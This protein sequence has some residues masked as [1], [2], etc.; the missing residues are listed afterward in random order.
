LA[1]G[2]KR[3]VGDKRTPEGAF[4]ICQKLR[5]SRKGGP[6]GPYFIR[7]DT[8]TQGWEGIGIHGTN[9]PETIGMK[10]TAGCI[11]MRNHDLA[12]LFTLLPL[13]TLV[14]IVP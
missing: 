2:D 3:A 5:L 8:R 14:T 9:R 13:G 6:F 12:E 4:R 10:A 11:R 7:L 1:G